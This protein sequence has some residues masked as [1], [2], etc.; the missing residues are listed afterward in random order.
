MPTLNYYSNL[1]KKTK[2]LVFL[3]RLASGRYDILAL[4]IR[5]LLC[6]LSEAKGS[7]ELN[8]FWKFPT[9][10][11][12]REESSQRPHPF[13][14]KRN[15]YRDKMAFNF[16]RN[17]LS[18]SKCYVSHGCLPQF[19]D[20]K[21]LPSK[22][23]PFSTIL[24]QHFTHTVRTCYRTQL[25]WMLKAESSDQVDLLL[26]EELYDSIWKDVEARMANVRYSRV[27]MSLSDLL[28]AEF[29]NTYIKIGIL[30]VSFF[31]R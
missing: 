16:A 24:N 23:K 26:S 20:P 4:K 11:L 21:Q 1:I 10:N 31:L 29:F 15:H 17:E 18:V 28:E 13:E 5:E 7:I 2:N 12:I 19:I 30:F 6:S 27:I 8:H 14:E 25:Y 3:T 9:S 22:K